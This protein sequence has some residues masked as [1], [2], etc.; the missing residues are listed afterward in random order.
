VIAVVLAI[1][2]VASVLKARRN[3][4][5]RAHAG[6]LRDTRDRPQPRNRGRRP[7]RKLG[8]V[9]VSPCVSGYARGS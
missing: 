7:A 3:P 4:E 9:G 1:T 8:V 6:P 2:V 5:A